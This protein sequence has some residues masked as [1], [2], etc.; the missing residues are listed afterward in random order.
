MKR[1]AA[2]KH[3]AVLA[4]G[5]LVQIALDNVDLTKVDNKNLTCV[6]V[7]L[8][9]H[10]QGTG[11]KRKQLDTPQYKVATTHGYLNRWT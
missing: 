5:G 10:T 9:T 11:G 4:V 2:V 8:K 6:V 7:E 3:G 1:A